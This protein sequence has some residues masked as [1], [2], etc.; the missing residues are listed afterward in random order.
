MNKLNIYYCPNCKNVGIA[1]GKAQF[2]CC[3]NKIEP[4]SIENC[5]N[6][7]TITEMDGEYLLEYASPMT[8]DDFIAA[9][10]VERYDRV[11]LIRLFSEQAAEVR[12]AQVKGAKI[13]TVFCRQGKVWCE[14][15]K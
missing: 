2:E 7:P 13:Y 3:G 4:L 12:V 14:V 9:V 11:E 8:K 10:I 15:M 5:S 1:Y 6:T